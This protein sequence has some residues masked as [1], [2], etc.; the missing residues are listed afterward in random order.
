M[1]FLRSNWPL[2]N[3]SPKLHMLEDHMTPFL[4]RW[5]VGFG[6]Y[7]E[8]GGESIHHQFKDMKIRYSNIKN[9]VDRL[10]YMV[11]Q[12]LLTTHPKAQDLQPSVKKRKLT[13]SK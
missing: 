12:H 5:H 6:F 13:F 10:K 2:E 8:Q 7:G 3:I 9:P 4:R 11:N 1:F